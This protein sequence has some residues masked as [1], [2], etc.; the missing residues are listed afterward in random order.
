M[1]KLHSHLR[2]FNTDI[3]SGLLNKVFFEILLYLYRRGHENVREMKPRDFE[4]ST[5]DNGKRFI[6][7]V[8][9]ELAKNHQGL[10][11]EQFEP[12]GVGMY[13]TRTPLCPVK[14]FIK[15]LDRRN[16]KCEACGNVQVK[17][18]LIM[19]FSLKGKL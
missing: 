15:Y 12:E 3:P 8:T 17:Y 13:K 4:V 2:V 19:K 18:L 11:N 10:C 1:Q 16:P 14:S 9:S 7:K 5:N 6:Y